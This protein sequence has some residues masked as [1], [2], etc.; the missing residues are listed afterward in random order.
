MF[1]FFSKRSEPIQVWFD[2]DIH[3]HVIPGVDDG[4]PDVDTSVRLISDLAALGIKRVIAS[5]HVTEGT[6]ENTP[7][8]IADAIARLQPA[9]DSAAVGVPVTNSAEYRIDDFF[10]KQIANNSLMPLPGNHLLVE[11][12]FIQEPWNIDNVIFDLRVKG[13]KPILAHPERYVYYHD[14]LER[15]RELHQNALFQ[16]NLLSLAGYYG[17][18][19]RK[20]AEWLIDNDLVDFIGTDTHNSRHIESLRAYLATRDARRHRDLTANR[21][22]NDTL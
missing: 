5:P 17:K 9:L 20:V 16:I 13:Y 18:N 7:D 19:I 1:N 2:T 22:L 11:N 10:A 4:S 15:Y 6:F 14:N 3:C 12:S 21:I 8:T